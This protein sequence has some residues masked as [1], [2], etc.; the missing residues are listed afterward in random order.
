M[1]DHDAREAI[2][3]KLREIASL[4]ISA[5]RFRDEPMMENVVKIA[6]I[7]ASL[8]A[9]TPAAKCGDEGQ[10]LCPACSLPAH[11]L[12]QVPGCGAPMPR[13]PFAI[14]AEQLGEIMQEEWGEI[15]EDAQAH[16]Q[17]IRHEGRKLFYDPRHWTAAIADRLNARI[18]TPAPA[19]G[20]AVAWGYFREGYAPIITTE[21]LAQATLLGATETPLY[22]GP[23]PP[24]QCA[25]IAQKSEQ[26]A[27]SAKCSEQATSPDGDAVEAL[28]KAAQNVLD[29][30]YVSES[31]EE[32]RSDHLALKQALSALANHSPDAGG[33]GEACVCDGIPDEVI[34]AGISAWDA[35]KH[36]ME[37]YV[38]GVTTDWDEGMI[39]AAIYKAMIA[40]LRPD[41]RGEG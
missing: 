15:C 17:D 29:R 28:R 12:T 33:V 3:R 8:P 21:R 20:E 39:V 19:S 23:Q 31:I 26:F 30:G 10:S 35:A 18:V 6:E 38:S 37:N 7:A 41:P 40:A 14:T 36:D 5:E 25:N 32:E 13:S 34:E 2:K 24:E 11:E 22:A 1:T 4:A 9:P 27:E 16:P